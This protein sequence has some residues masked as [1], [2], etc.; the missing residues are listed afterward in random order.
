MRRVNLERARREPRLFLRPY[1]RATLSL[2]GK[3]RGGGVDPQTRG[4]RAATRD[5]FMPAEQCEH[6]GKRAPEVKG[7][8]L[9]LGPCEPRDLGHRGSNKPGSGGNLR[10]DGEVQDACGVGVAGRLGG[11][12]FLNGLTAVSCS[13]ELLPNQDLSEL[14]HQFGHRIWP[15]NDAVGEGATMPQMPRAALLNLPE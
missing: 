10:V 14:F 3:C 6:R 4:A 15:I 7:N 1:Q 12:S 8:A 5:D 2:I 13:P 9:P 11:I